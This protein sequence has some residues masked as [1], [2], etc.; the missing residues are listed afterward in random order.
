MYTKHNDTPTPTRSLAPILVHIPVSPKS[1]QHVRTQKRLR[2]RVA[3]CSRT[4]DNVEFVGAIFMRM[5]SF[6]HSLLAT[7]HTLRTCVLTPPH[8]THQPRHIV[9]IVRTGPQAHYNNSVYTQYTAHN[10]HIDMRQRW[11][12]IKPNKLLNAVSSYF[13]TS[14]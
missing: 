6:I 2:A 11:G 4:W 1:P 9:H 8:Q 7:G 5:D 3:R 13:S 10:E 14:L 12:S